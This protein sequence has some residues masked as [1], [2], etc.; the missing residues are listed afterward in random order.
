MPVVGGGD[1]HSVEVLA[2]EEP[3][4]VAGGID[5]LLQNLPGRLVASFVEVRDG[6][7]LN[8]GYGATGP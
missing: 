4:V 6:D 7:A 2:V 8:A 3:A 5:V 1:N